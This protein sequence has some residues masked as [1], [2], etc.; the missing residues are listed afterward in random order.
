MTNEKIIGEE[1]DYDIIISG[2]VDEYLLTRSPCDTVYNIIAEYLDG[3]DEEEL[4][5]MQDDYKVK[6]VA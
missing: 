5:K 2:M 6:A 3:L 4:Q 1:I